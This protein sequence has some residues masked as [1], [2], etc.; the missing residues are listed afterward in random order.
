[1]E[2]QDQTANTLS[3]TSFWKGLSVLCPFTRKGRKNIFIH[4]IVSEE[5]P[6]AHGII[7]LHTEFN[8]NIHLLLELNCCR[9]KGSC[10]HFRPCIEHPALLQAMSI[11][12]KLTWAIWLAVS[13]ALEVPYITA[14]IRTSPPFAV[15]PHTFPNVQVC[16]KTV[17]RMSFVIWIQHNMR[18]PIRLRKKG[19]NSSKVVYCICASRIHLYSSSAYNGVS[20]PETSHEKQMHSR[21]ARILH[22]ARR[23]SCVSIRMHALQLAVSPNWPISICSMTREVQP[24]LPLS[25]TLIYYNSTS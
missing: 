5:Y 7:P 21:W 18:Q 22:A 1:M 3:S 2:S 8:K 10:L 14:Y 4:K 16:F 25:K 9:T 11:F 13:L 19:P 15:S 12:R 20:S 17:E 24:S 23:R 6:R